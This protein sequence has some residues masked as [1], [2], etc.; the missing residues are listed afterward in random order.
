[1][2]FQFSYFIKGTKRDFEIEARSPYEA[3]RFAEAQADAIR[4]DGEGL[5][6][7]FYAEARI[8]DEGYA[9]PAYM[10]EGTAPDGHEFLVFDPRSSEC[11]RFQVDP[12]ESYGVSPELLAE[13]DA[14]NLTLL[15]F[16]PLCA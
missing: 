15:G 14:K 11:G 13:L 5:K 6:I 2:K 16:V 1:M 7:V 3:L 10:I 9:A 4:Y 8:N 12:L